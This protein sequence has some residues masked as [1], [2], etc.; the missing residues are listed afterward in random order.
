MHR[1]VAQR[2]SPSARRIRSMP[3][4]MLPHWSPPP[5][6]QQ[7]QRTSPRV[8]PRRCKQLAYLHDALLLGEQL[9]EVVRL[10]QLVRKL[11]E[12]QASLAV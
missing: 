12:A 8:V 6:Y 7:V 4:V 10:E 1:R 2:T 3:A 11:G 5:T 9:S